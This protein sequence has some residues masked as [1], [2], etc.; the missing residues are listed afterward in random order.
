M[1]D[2]LYETIGG[3]NVIRAAIE[4]F[5]RRVLADESLRH[6]FASTDMAHLRS[7]QSMFVSMLV[8]GK[9]IYT[10]KE[11]GPAHA[12]ARSKGLTAGHFDAFLRHFRDSLDEVGV[13]PEN[14]EKVIQLLE[15]KRDAVLGG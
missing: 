6:F 2:T 9:A 13:K 4:A 15:S 12:A 8:G 3:R 1:I 5:Y 14:A 7:G 10:G 11:I